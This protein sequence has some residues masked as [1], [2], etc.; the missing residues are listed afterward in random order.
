MYKLKCNKQL[1]TSIYSYNPYSSNRL[2]V[3]LICT[4]CK[5][6]FAPATT[7]V[8]FAPKRHDLNTINLICTVCIIAISFNP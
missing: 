3:S 4:G 8:P 5:F 1:P 6:L 7:K 2:H